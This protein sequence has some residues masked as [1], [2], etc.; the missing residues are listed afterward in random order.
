MKLGKI[1]A[2]RHLLIPL[3]L[4]C[5]VGCGVFH[6]SSEVV[7][8]AVPV[9]ANPTRAGGTVEIKRNPGKFMLA[10]SSPVYEHPDKASAV[11]AY[12]PQG[13][14][15]NVTAVAG[16]WLLIRL[17]DGKVGFI[18]NDSVKQNKGEPIT[19]TSE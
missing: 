14:Y 10:E 1:I 3:F 13:A 16:A 15:E 19:G 12:I 6:D 11:I 5:S 18:P 4:C 17:P 8:P 9:G 2:L 7:L